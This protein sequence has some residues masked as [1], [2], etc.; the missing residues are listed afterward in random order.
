MTS[1][2]NPVKPR[3]SG[4]PDFHEEIPRNPRPLAA[5]TIPG[6]SLALI[7]LATDSTVSSQPLVSK[8][9]TITL[10]FT[11]QGFQ[12]SGIVRIS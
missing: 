10:T 12:T 7:C 5:C 6:P 1:K 2:Q 4:I 3:I 9:S 8:G 11:F